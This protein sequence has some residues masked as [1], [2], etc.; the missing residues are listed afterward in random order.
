MKWK[1]SVNVLSVSILIILCFNLVGGAESALPS[2]HNI[3]NVTQYKQMNGLMCGDAALETMFNFWGADI[4][5][6]SIADVARTSSIGTYT[7]DMVR[8]GHFSHL[9]AANGSYFP[10][11][12]PTA[13]FPERPMGY[14]S[15]SYSN[16]TFWLSGLEALVAADIP[17]VLL[18]KY[19]PTDDAG[20]YR[21]IVGYNNT[22]GEIYFIDPWGRDQKRVT[23][24]DGTV[25]WTIADFQNAWNYSEYGTPHPFWGA[26]MMPW[27]VK[28][29]TSGE[30]TAGSTVNVSANIT[31]PCPQ[32]FNCSTYPASSAI[33]KIIL[34]SYMHVKDGSSTIGI[35]NLVAGSNI[36]VSW[37]VTAD[38]DASG[39]DI[40]V[41]AGGQISGAV[42]QVFWNGNQVSYP[43]YSYIDEIGGEGKV[44]L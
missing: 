8:T 9:S 37:K 24:P 20:H 16:D 38:A 30:P 26:V 21:V 31:Y 19:A 41:S 27:S 12:A 4:N 29:T 1:K 3:T 36:T 13:G 15:F 34:P 23:N 40:T 22:K 33:A 32:P 44:R 35:G 43:A 7:W 6:K 11:D 42:P 18:M 17:V 2:A 5:Q 39:S 14:A 25:T 10:H 28:L